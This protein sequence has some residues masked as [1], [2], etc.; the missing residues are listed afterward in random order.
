MTDTMGKQFCT[1]PNRMNN[2]FNKNL[3]RREIRVGQSSFLDHLIAF[4][5]TFP[6]PG[7]KE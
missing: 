3:D 4:S 1:N 5:F 7:L 6:S 2:Q